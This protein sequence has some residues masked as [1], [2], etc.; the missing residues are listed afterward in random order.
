MEQNSENNIH[1]ND[2][3]SIE[4]IK[5]GDKSAFEA[6]F[7]KH[8]S[9]VM[10]LSYRYVRSREI[11]EEI[12]QDVF[13]KVY[14]GRVSF[15]RNTKFSTWLYRVTVNASLDYVRKRKFTPFSLDAPL[16]ASD[17]DPGT[18][19]LESLKDK[20]SLPGDLEIASKEIREYVR[21]AVDSLP[22]KLR[23]P[24]L[25]YQF[26]AMPYRDIARILGIS[27]KAVERRLYHAKGILRKKLEKIL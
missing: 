24:T 4:N 12:A 10:N 16:R 22:D 21:K 7:L 14:E 20:A 17:E 11:A 1:D 15:Q 9:M 3:T 5:Q 23:Q 18:T 8:K 26:D 25:L 13:I 19:F 6:L 2:W 27:E